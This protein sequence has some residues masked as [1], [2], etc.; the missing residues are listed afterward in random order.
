[1]S[2]LKPLIHG[3]MRVTDDMDDLEVQLIEQALTTFAEGEG[4]CL[5]TI[6]YEYD[7]GSQ[8]AL[9][10]IHELQRSEARHVVV[11]SLGQLAESQIVQVLMVDRVELETGAAMHESRRD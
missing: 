4:Y 6:F 5:G 7:S 1:M 8:A 3:Y 9:A 2:D 10:V 11:L